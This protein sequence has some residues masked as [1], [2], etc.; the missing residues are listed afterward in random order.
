MGVFD[1]ESND[2]DV[3]SPREEQLVEAGEKVPPYPWWISIYLQLF[4]CRCDRFAKA[5]VHC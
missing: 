4:L 1:L 3:M 5:K 2:N